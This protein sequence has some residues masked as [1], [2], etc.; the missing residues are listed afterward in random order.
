M[1]PATLIDQYTL[2]M[3][4][5]EGDKEIRYAAPP[6]KKL[7]AQIV[8]G[9]CEHH[10]DITALIDATLRDNWKKDRMS[11]LI[12]ALMEAAFYELAHQE[13]L[14]PAML[15]NE[16]VTLTSSFFGQPELGFINAALDATAKKIHG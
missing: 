6:D 10:E 16:Y 13:K 12:I 14:K 15:I 2:Q 7:M 8:T 1:N 9:V 11:P 5:Q 4:Q 3:E